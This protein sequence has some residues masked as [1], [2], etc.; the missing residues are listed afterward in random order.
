MALDLDSQGD[1]VEVVK[2][3]DGVAQA[4]VVLVVEVERVDRL[5]HRAV[6]DGLGGLQWS[7][8][9]CVFVSSSWESEAS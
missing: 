7:G 9:G 4:L 3:V 6:V 5:V 1:L 8:L 2:G